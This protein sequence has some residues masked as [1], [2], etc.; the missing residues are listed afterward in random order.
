MRELIGQTLGHFRILAKIGEGGMG[1]VY[2]AHD[3]R[4]DRDVAVKVLPEEVSQDVER[5]VVFA[6]N[7]IRVECLPS[8]VVDQTL[9]AKR[10]PLQLG[11]GI[12][13]LPHRELRTR[14]ERR[15]LQTVLQRTGWDSAA[16]ARILGI[17]YT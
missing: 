3:E 17:Q 8:H 16:S 7:P 10:G 11:E 4:L 6:G 15:Y 12:P 14:C 2:R 1:E 5:H 9:T 13:T